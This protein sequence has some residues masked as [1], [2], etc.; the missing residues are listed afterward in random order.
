MIVRLAM[1]LVLATAAFSCSS[2]TDEGQGDAV[3]DVTVD[4]ADDPDAVSDSSVVPDAPADDVPAVDTAVEPD[5][6]QDTAV[7][8]AIDVAVDVTP[9]NGGSVDPE[10]QALVA[11]TV[12]NFDVDGKK[13]QFVL[14][15]PAMG[16]AR[17]WPVVFNWHGFGDTAVNMSSLLASYV[18]S[19]DFQ[20]ILVTPEDLDLQPPSGMDW[21]ILSIKTPNPEARL[22]DE[23]LACLDQMYGVDW[24]R[25]HSVGFSAGAIAT[26]LMGVLRGDVIASLVSFSGTYFSD[27][28]NVSALGF[29]SSYVSWPEL[30]TANKYSQL[31][32]H[33]SNADNYNLQVVTLQF[34]ENGI[35]DVAYLN[36]LG[37]DVVHCDHGQGH[38]IPSQMMGTPIVRFLADHPKGT[39]SPWVTAGI[40]A[41]FPAYC[42]MSPAP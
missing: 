26:D 24:D 22:F 28:G 9:D 40:P 17:K 38:T 8:V 14:N 1:T 2:G 15:L 6:T 42:E 25:V 5:A 29:L 32:V 34:D 35:R 20:F 4:V 23:V 30:T 16:E 41:S 27:A 21:D 7:D 19:A 36:D 18:N 13:R 31:L 37:H 3:S 11:G 12:S 39:G 10:C 33:G